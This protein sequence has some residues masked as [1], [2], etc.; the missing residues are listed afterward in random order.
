VL[1]VVSTICYLVF[2]FI[3]LYQKEKKRNKKKNATA[4][5]GF[6][7][8]EIHGSVSISLSPFQF[9]NE[10]RETSVSKHGAAATNLSLPKIFVP[11]TSSYDKRRQGY[12]STS[13]VL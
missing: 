7:L 3:Y 6:P 11:H 5:L 13:L 12:T 2:F 4:S 8:L 1:L 10:F 9:V